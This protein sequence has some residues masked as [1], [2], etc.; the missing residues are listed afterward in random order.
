[1]TNSID[2][3]GT[4]GGSS[5]YA[6]EDYVGT[7]GAPGHSETYAQPFLAKDTYFPSSDKA[8]Q[9]SFMGSVFK[10]VFSALG[11]ILSGPSGCSPFRLPEHPSPHFSKR[12]NREIL[13][14]NIRKVES[15]LAKKITTPHTKMGRA[16][17]LLPSESEMTQLGVSDSR[18]RNKILELRSRLL[19]RTA[20]L[21]AYDILFIS[22]SMSLS[23]KPEEIPYAM[24]CIETLGNLQ[25]FG[26]GQMMMTYP[27]GMGGLGGKFLAGE[28]FALRYGDLL[29]SLPQEAQEKALRVATLDCDFHMGHKASNQSFLSLQKYVSAPPESQVR[30]GYS[31]QRV[32]VQSAMPLVGVQSA[33][34]QVSVYEFWIDNCNSFKEPEGIDTSKIFIGE[35]LHQQK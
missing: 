25:K 6:N 3:L 21:L 2:S 34:P 23:P 1:M 27:D 30:G 28:Y 22:R 7:G 14:N 9:E 12:E 11:Y 33:M 35:Y 31:G 4:G 8:S 15:L 10:S 13:Q 24:E 26:L 18:V 32:G 29:V 17:S 19:T 16:L 20:H 5:Y